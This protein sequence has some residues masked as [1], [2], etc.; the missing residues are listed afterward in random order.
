MKDPLLPPVSP[1]VERFSWA[2]PQGGRVLD[3]ACGSGRHLHYLLALGYRVTGVDRDLA[4][5]G[6]LADHP[7]LDLIARDLED[8]TP[9]ALGSRRFDGVLVT[10]YLFR[11]LLP[12]LV[13]AVAPGGALLYETFAVGNERFG[14][15][16]NP[17]FLLRPGELI[18]A[19]QSALR[20]LAYEDLV[21]S[22]PRPGAVQRIVARREEE[23]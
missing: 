12:G 9:F 6:T 4:R 17:D 18:E 5:V 13:A 2:I 20:I 19:V 22:E 7:N 10:N 1:W 23:D 21:V 3:L 8:G 16:R 11:P 14:R 15:P